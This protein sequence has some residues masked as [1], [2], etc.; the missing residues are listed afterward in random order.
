VPLNIIDRGSGTPVVVI[1]GVQGRWEWM[2][3]AIDELA[4][5]CRVITFSL[6]DE[7]TSGGTFD[8]QRGFW[9]YVDQVREVLDA[10]GLSRAAICGISYGGLIAAAFAAR[11]A[12]RTASLILVSALPP[13]WRPDTR[14]NFYLRAP[15]LLTP[16]FLVGSL[17]LYK[18]IAV[19][20]SETHDGG[21]A[22]VS[23]AWRALTHMF[24]PFRMARRAGF[25]R[26][27][28][29]QE[30]LS[31]VTVPTL[32]VTGEP[33]LDRV[34]PVAATLQYTRLWP[35]ALVATIAHTGHLGLTT[36]PTEFARLVV[37]FA[38]DADR[39]DVRRQV[40]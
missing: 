2:R 17:R 38:E 23:H 7:P 6:A 16:V 21:R 36:R 40:G 4:Q 30:D 1:P 28:V 18:E 12:D 26:S 37:P 31:H 13:S 34:V 35:H 10:L 5:R 19:A 14:L 8:E 22:A 9:C 27:L 25:L 15:K 29:L 32:V 11:H 3:P 39:I 33:G 20:R 24:S